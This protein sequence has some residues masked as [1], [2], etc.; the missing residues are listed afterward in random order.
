MLLRVTISEG[1]GMIRCPFP[2]FMLEEGKLDSI[3]VHERTE[4]LKA[5]EEEGLVSIE[6]ITEKEYQDVLKRTSDRLTK[7]A[8]GRKRAQLQRL[9]KT[10]KAEKSILGSGYELAVEP[11]DVTPEEL[12]AEAEEE[13][14]TMEKTIERNEAAKT[15]P[16]SEVPETPEPAGEVPEEQLPPD[17]IANFIAAEKAA[18]E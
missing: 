4:Q 6:T 13:L 3:F 14:V 11:G 7:R 10:G 12:S 16:V 2:A 1:T 5:L 18:G 9:I 8:I 17:D 15:A